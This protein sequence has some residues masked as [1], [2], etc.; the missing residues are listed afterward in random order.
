MLKAIGVIIWTLCSSLIAENI[1]QLVPWVRDSEYYS[2]S[3]APDAEPLTS[4]RYAHDAFPWF[5]V[6]LLTWVMGM[7]LWIV[8][9]SLWH[10]LHI[11]ARQA[12]RRG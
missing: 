6:W 12:R 10:R 9:S 11:P 1:G 4:W 2:Y 5:V 7:I 3:G 8:L